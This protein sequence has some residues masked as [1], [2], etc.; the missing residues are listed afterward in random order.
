MICEGFFFQNAQ[1]LCGVGCLESAFA[2]VG[3]SVHIIPFLEIGGQ[4]L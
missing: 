4:P 2:E 1:R 3:S